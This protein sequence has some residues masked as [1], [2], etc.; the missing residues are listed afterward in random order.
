MEFETESSA[1]A[2]HRLLEIGQK[3]IPSTEFDVFKTLEAFG[4][5]SKIEQLQTDQARQDRMQKILEEVRVV[6]AHGSSDP[7]T[8]NKL[9][10]STTLWSDDEK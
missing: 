10:E 9:A 8:L 2:I 7:T 4:L 6:L 1:A 3:A 5:A